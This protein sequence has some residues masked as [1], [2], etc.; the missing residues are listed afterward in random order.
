MMSA[1]LLCGR[2]LASTAACRRCQND[3]RRPL[4]VWS[5][6]GT[7]QGV[8]AFFHFEWHVR[9][10]L[11][12][13]LHVLQQQVDFNPA[14]GGSHALARCPVRRRLSTVLS[15]RSPFNAPVSCASSRQSCGRNDNS[16]SQSSSTVPALRVMHPHARIRRPRCENKLAPMGQRPHPPLFGQPARPDHGA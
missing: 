7:E 5:V 4:P 8:D 9:R 13:L 2:M 10:A 14:G 3:G 11:F 16:T 15:L 1:I 12:H 6:R